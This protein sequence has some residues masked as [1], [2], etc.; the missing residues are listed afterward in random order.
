MFEE[1]FK[2]FDAMGVSTH[3]K[4]KLVTYQLK[5]VAQVWYEQKKDERHV[6]EGRITWGAFKMDNFYRDV[7]SVKE[8]NLKFTQLSKHATTMV[9]DSREKMK[10]FVMGYLILW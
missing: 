2:V 8:Y 6:I 3:E 5:N 4:A 1:V 9:V 7:M 10:K